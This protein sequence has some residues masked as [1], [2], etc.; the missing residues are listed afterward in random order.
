MSDQQTSRVCPPGA[1]YSASAENSQDDK[2]ATLFHFSLLLKIPG[3]DSPAV[4]DRT[5]WGFAFISHLG[6]EDVNE[7]T[8]TLLK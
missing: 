7:Q 5:I 2:C 6:P 1:V 3:D 8:L 4:K